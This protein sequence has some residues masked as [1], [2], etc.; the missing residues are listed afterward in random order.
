MSKGAHMPNNYV[1]AGILN[2]ITESLYDNPIVVFREYVQ[3]SMD[4]FLKDPKDEHEIQIWQEEN[5]LFFLD[6]GNGIQADKFENEMKTIGGSTKRRTQNIGYKG[7]GRLSGV[8]YCEKLYFLNILDY[9]NGILQQFSIDGT[10]YKNIKD[11]EDADL[12]F[13]HLIDQIGEYKQNI[14]LQNCPPLIK[15]AVKKHHEMLSRTNNGFFVILSDIRYVLKSAIG[16][17]DFF[18]NLQWLL[19]VDFAPELYEEDYSYRVLFEDFTQTK[20]GTDSIIKYCNIYYNNKKIL[21]PITKESIRTYICKK[22]Y[23]YAIGFHTF[24]NDR[25]FIEKNNNFSG[26]RLYIDNMLLCDETELIQN[27]ANFGLLHRPLNGS[28]QAA[29]GIGAMIYIT[30]KV[31]ISANARRTFFEVTDSDS[32]KFLKKLASFVENVYDARYAL[33]NYYSA[34]DK[35]LSD[36]KKLKT[37]K[38]KALK[39]LEELASLEIKVTTDDSIPTFDTL[40]DI[41]KRKILKNNLQKKLDEKS[42]EFIRWLN[43]NEFASMDQNLLLSKFLEW[44]A[45][46]K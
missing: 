33:S 18:E 39:N 36:T 35:H 7:I 29:C 2:V 11:I 43:P 30:D 31:N 3:N 23:D 41:E 40:S 12:T 17:K 15:N 34:R 10:K 22:N 25:I 21:R 44:L 13:E 38:E 42:K 27:L 46:N 20:D 19:P 6:N 32:I 45:S 28:I 5:S 9:K 14:N 1:G 26:I 4:S 8:P 24:R 37:Y 16:D